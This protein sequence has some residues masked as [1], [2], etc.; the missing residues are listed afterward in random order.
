LRTPFAHELETALSAGAEATGYLVEAYKAF[1]A[2]PNAPASITTDHDRRAQEIIL[3]AIRAEFPGDALCAE[4]DTPTLQGVERTGAR[5]WIVDPIDGTRGFAQKNGEFSVMIGFVTE[6]AL[7]VGVVAEPVKARVTYAT[8]AGGCW[9]RDGAADPVPC[10]VST[11]ARLEDATLIQSRSRTPTQQAQLLRPARIVETHSAGVK[12]ACVARGEAD[13]YVNYYPNFSDWDIC[14]GQLLVTEAG[15][16]VTGM[17]GQTLVYGLP[18]AH[19]RHGLLAA[20]GTL[21]QLALERLS[22][23]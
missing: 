10:R 11:T 2:I 17:K 4:E 20:N 7:A 14:A 21:H 16:V 12:L 13:I 3:Q 9:A 8:L 22:A 23:R 18:G 19:Q 1:E 15:G 5:L 6:G